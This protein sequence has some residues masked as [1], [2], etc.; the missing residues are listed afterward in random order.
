MAHLIS[1]DVRDINKLKDA[2]DAF[3]A[4]YGATIHQEL[5]QTIEE[6]VVPVSIFSQGLS[7][8]ESVTTYLSENMSMDERAIAKALHK[9][10]SSIRTAYQSAKRKLHGQLSAQPSPYGL[11]LSS[12][13]SDSLS[14]LELVS[15]HLHDKHGLSF[16]AVGRLLGKNERTIWTA[17]HRAKQK[18]LA[19]N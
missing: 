8:L 10:S 15:S 13:A 17:A 1:V 4:K 11:P 2:V 19:K 5:S 18:W 12:L 9:Q 3:T 16:R 7:P 14:I 6:P